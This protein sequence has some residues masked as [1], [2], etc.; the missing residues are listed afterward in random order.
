MYLY[1]CTCGRS[2]IIRCGWMCMLWGHTALVGLLT[3]VHTC[4]QSIAT[5]QCGWSGRSIS[6]RHS[7]SIK[8]WFVLDRAPMLCGWPNIEA[9]SII[10]Y[11]YASGFPSY[12]MSP[13]T[14]CRYLIIFCNIHEPANY[15]YVCVYV[16]RIVCLCFSFTFCS[17]YCTTDYTCVNSEMGEILPHA[18]LAIWQMYNIS[19]LLRDLLWTSVYLY[20][21]QH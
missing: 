5:P 2:G 10:W 7:P 12:H 3:W 13:A 15:V 18:C 21:A 19:L 6:C 8:K 17:S 4:S 11:M 16:C 9:R 20:Y 14:V 1:T